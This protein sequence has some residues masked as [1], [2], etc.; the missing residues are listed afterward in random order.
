MVGGVSMNT[1]SIEH[2]LREIGFKFNDWYSFLDLDNFDSD[3]LVEN[4]TTEGN[5]DR[6]FLWSN[7][8]FIEK[9]NN[10]EICIIALRQ[11]ESLFNL[12]QLMF[13]L[14]H[15]SLQACTFLDL[16]KSRPPR[17]IRQRGFTKL[18]NCNTKS[19]TTFRRVL[20]GLCW[21]IV[22][23]GGLPVIFS[24]IQ[25][26]VLPII[27]QKCLD[28]LTNI[29]CVD[30]IEWLVLSRQSWF[31]DKLVKMVNEGDLQC[32]MVPAISVIDRLVVV[33]LAENMNAAYKQ[34]MDSNF[35]SICI[36]Q[37]QSPKGKNEMSKLHFIK[38]QT[39]AMQALA[40]L[41]QDDRSAKWEKV[42]QE[43]V[44]SHAYQCA[45][46]WNTEQPPS[47][48]TWDK[49]ESFYRNMSFSSS[50]LLFSLIILI[51]AVLKWPGKRKHL[52][53]KGL[54]FQYQLSKMM[55]LSLSETSNSKDSNVPII[56]N[57]VEWLLK[58]L[59]GVNDKDE[60]C[61]RVET[62]LSTAGLFSSILNPISELCEKVFRE[63]SYKECGKRESQTGQWNTCPHCNVVCYCSSICK[64]ADRKMNHTTT[65]CSYLSMKQVD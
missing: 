19:G 9:C 8:E 33:I 65:K 59:T 52:Q 16:Q 58:S 24:M 1:A 42:L 30:H 60:N 6:P 61:S 41:C 10:G 55:T 38:F 12:S 53:K 3:H 13:A 36:D 25:N 35:I 49:S 27:Q 20:H 23:Q 26:P 51:H 11:A 44:F 31:L 28:A 48:P 17:D 40:L 64:E 5:D 39:I 45:L 18:E 21:E 32:D 54:M 34:L 62:S 50:A 4:L 46:V 2:H 43:R 37:L 29:L 15:G 22:E 63:C 14:Y 47:D 7:G 57:A 56:K